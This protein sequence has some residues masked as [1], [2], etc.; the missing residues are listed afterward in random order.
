MHGPRYIWITGVPLV[1]LVVVC[2]TAGWQKIF[3]DAPALG[4]LAQANALDA[5]PHTAVTSQLVFN[6]RLDAAVTAVFLV[7]VAAILIDSVRV[8]IGVLA[9]GRKPKTTETPFVLSHLPEE[10]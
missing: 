7:L 3:A 4:F 1:W 10:A 8:W 6:A 9:G 2:F 5:G